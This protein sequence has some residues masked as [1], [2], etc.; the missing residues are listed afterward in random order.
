MQDLSQ[1]LQEDLK[2]VKVN[3][4]NYPKLASKY[5]IQVCPKPRLLSV[6]PW[7]QAL[8]N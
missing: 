7:V 3:T 8:A 5:R 2:V 4:D 1:E 6:L